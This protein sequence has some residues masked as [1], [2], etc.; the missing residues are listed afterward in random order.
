M[1]EF[2]RMADACLLAQKS[3]NLTGMTVPGRLQGYMSAG[4]PVIAATDGAAKQVIEESGCGVCVG[5]GDSVALAAAL[6]NFHENRFAYERCGE[7]ARA[8]YEEHFAKHVFMQQIEGALTSLS[9]GRSVA[10]GT[11]PRRSRRG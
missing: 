10:D 5:A 9:E 2:Y 7:N 4:K 8:Y 11:T 3:D 1:A 6:K